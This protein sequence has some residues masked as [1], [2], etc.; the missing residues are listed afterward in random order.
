M[1][2]CGMLTKR[3]FHGYWLLSNL[4]QWEVNMGINSEQAK[5]GTV[6]TAIFSSLTFT[7]IPHSVFMGNFLPSNFF[8]VPPNNLQ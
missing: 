6:R 3:G 7:K 2:A 8:I 4:G 1:N 5:I